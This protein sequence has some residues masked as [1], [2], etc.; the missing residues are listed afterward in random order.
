M[1][2]DMTEEILSNKEK[3]L[4]AQALFRLS[5]SD[6]IYEEECDND[7]DNDLDIEY[8]CMMVKNKILNL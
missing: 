8:R 4:I 1:D 6:C 2:I 5:C 7:L 3:E